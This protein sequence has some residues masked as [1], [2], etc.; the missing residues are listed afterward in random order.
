MI[1]TAVH[2]CVCVSDVCSSRSSVVFIR[3]HLLKKR[4]FHHINREMPHKSSVVTKL[5]RRDTTAAHN[6]TFCLDESVQ[7]RTFLVI[8]FYQVSL[9]PPILIIIMLAIRQCVVLF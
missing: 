9:F 6:V 3:Q 4:L 5:R 1:F 8:T 7:D 2:Y